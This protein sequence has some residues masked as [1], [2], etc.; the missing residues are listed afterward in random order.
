MSQPQWSVPMV[1]VNRATLQKQ[2]L[3][4]SNAGLLGAS[5]GH[6]ATA[7]IARVL[8]EATK[9]NCH[10]QRV[11]TSQVHLPAQVLHPDVSLPPAGASHLL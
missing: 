2:L 9:C 10:M 4:G 3:A 5:P 11:L 7:G 6:R 8:Q 1:C